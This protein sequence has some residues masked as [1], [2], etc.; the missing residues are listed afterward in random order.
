MLGGCDP[1]C[2]GLRPQALEAATPCLQAAGGWLSRCTRTFRVPASLGK[3]EYWRSRRNFSY[4][5]HLYCVV[6]KC[7]AV[8]TW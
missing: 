2:A 1:V 7:A 3:S 6:A 8:R 5:K 4:Y